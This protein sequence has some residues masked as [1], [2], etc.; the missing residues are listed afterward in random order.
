MTI[1]ELEEKIEDL[2]HE[3]EQL[4]LQVAEMLE[5]CDDDGEELD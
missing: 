1:K 5:E 2:E 4:A 3:K